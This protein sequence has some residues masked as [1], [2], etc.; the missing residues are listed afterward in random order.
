ML[1]VVSIKKASID[2]GYYLKQ[3][4]DYY[5][6]GGNDK[7]L[8]Q[9]VGKG[10]RVL[11]L[12]GDVTLKDH[13]NVFNGILPGNI[14]VGKRNPDGSLAG[15]PGYDLTF[16]MNKD[17]SLII[18]CTKDK[19]LKD[20]FLNAHIS[21]VKTVMNEVENL[22]SARKTVNGVTGYEFTKN[23]V[24][25]LCTHF[26]SRAGDPEVHTHALI[27]NATQRDDGQWR[28]LSTDM[29]REHG[30]F[31][32]VRDNA[33]F[34]GH[35]Y[36]NEMARATKEK[37]FGVVPIKKHGMFAI[38]SFPDDVKQHFSKRRVQIEGIVDSL[39][40]A[41]KTDRML[42][43][44]VAQ[45][46]RPTKVNIKHHDLMAKSKADMKDYLDAHHNHKDF[47]TLIKACMDKEEVQ[48]ERATDTSHEA[49][50]D[51]VKSLSRFNVSMDANAIIKKAMSYDLGSSSIQSLWVSLEDMIKGDV[52]HRTSDGHLT[53][54][55][56]IDKENQLMRL[57]NRM[58]PRGQAG[59]AVK[60]GG[61]GLDALHKE[62]LCVLEEPS[63][64]NDKL[65]MLDTLI[66]DL[67]SAGKTVTLLTQTKSL[68][69]KHN[70]HSSVHPQSL[71]QRLIRLKKEDRAKGLYGFLHQEESS[72]RQGSHQHQPVWVIDDA[73]R[74]NLDAAERLLKLA[75]KKKAGLIFLSDEKGRQSTNIVSLL[76]KSKVTYISADDHKKAK[77]IDHLSCHVHEI[78]TDF[79][80]KPH[81]KQSDRQRQLADNIVRQYG[82]TL[83]S[84]QI[85]AMTA[86]SAKKQSAWVRQALKRA[87]LIGKEDQQI[88]TEKTVYLSAEEKKHAKFFKKGWVVKTYVGKGQFTEKS[89]ERLDEKNN[90]LVVKGTFGREKFILPRQLL[91]DPDA[92]LVERASLLISDQER[93]RVNK[94]GRL[95]KQLGLSVNTCYQVS[96]QGKKIR[97]QPDDSTLKTINTTLSR[98]RGADL[99]HDYVRSLNQIQNLQRSDKMAIL[100]APSY[101]LNKGVIHTLGR[102]F[103]RLDCYTDNSEKA[104]K[105]MGIQID[106]VLASDLPLAPEKPEL[107]TLQKAVNY[108]IA[109]IAS[110]E[111]AFTY[112]SVVEKSLS[113][114][115]T[116]VNFKSIR[117]ELRDRVKAGELMARQSPTG[118]IVIATQETI[119]LEQ[120]IIQ[121]I[122]S[123]K[124]SVTPFLGQADVQQK[125]DATS[126][127]EGQ[128]AACALLATTSDRFVM[129]QGYAGTGKSTML[130]TLQAAIETSGVIDRER[131]IAVAPTH[132]AVQELLL[133]GIQAQTLKSFLVDEVVSENH[134]HLKDKLILLD[135]S[136]MVS[137]RDWQMLE[138]VVEKAESCHCAYIGDKAQLLGVEDG[139]PS[140]LA[141]FSR[142]A[143]IATAT[144]DEV[145]R[146]KTPELKNVVRELVAGT[147]ESMGRAFSELDKQ[148]SIID[149]AS[150]K[151][152]EVAHPIQR[153]AEYY[154]NLSKSD[155]AQTVIAAATNKSRAA[156]NH[157]IRIIRQAKGELQGDSVN[158]TILID[159]GLT[160]AELTHAP[161]YKKDNVVKFNDVYFDVVKADRQQNM[162]LLKDGEGQEQVLNLNEIAPYAKLEL[163]YRETIEIQAGDELKWTKSDKARKLT[164]HDGLLVSAVNNQDSTITAKTKD[165]ESLAIDLSL[166][167]NQHMDYRY[168]STVH[169]LQGATAKLALV[170]LDFSNRLSN[171]MR[172]LYVAATRATHEVKVFTN[173]L[174]V[175][176][177]QIAKNKGDKASAL[178]AMGLLPIKQPVA[179]GSAAPSHVSA[180]P[181]PAVQAI[182]P[183]RKGRSSAAPPHVSSKPKPAAQ[184]I[185]PHQRKERIDA[186]LVEDGLRHQVQTICE[187]FFGKPKQ[188]LSNANNWRYGKKGS[189]SVSVGGSYQ[190]SFHN[191][192]TG[193]KGGMIQLLMSELG[194]DFKAA[195]EEGHRMVGGD[196]TIKPKAKMKAPVVMDD[197]ANARKLSYL[198]S[199]VERSQSIQ[200]TVAEKY[201]AGRAIQH[202]S[203][204][205][206]RYIKDINT[207]G[208]NQDIKRYADGLLAIAKDALGQMTAIQVT[209]LDPKTGTKVTGL[210]IKKRTIGSLK[211]SSV[212]LTPEVTSPNL[213][214]VAEGIETALSIKDAIASAEKSQVQ[215]LATLGKSNLAKVAN[216]RSADK[217]VLV[218]DNDKQDWQ[219][220]KS[221]K[222]AIAQME[223]QGKDVR[224]IQPKLINDQKTDY[225]DLAK[226]G[227]FDEIRRDIRQGIDQL[228][229]KT[230]PDVSKTNDQTNLNVDKNINKAMRIDRD[231]FG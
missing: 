123:G 206:L 162:V 131:I 157:N 37:G 177:E 220:D 199:L 124:N 136:S 69:E 126:L 95:T 49:V 3:D 218:L 79:N 29:Q 101:A 45:H 144:M 205:D 117:S 94:A 38:E 145:L 204:T 193:E 175:V 8:Y 180:K 164:A 99:S 35:I 197:S 188:S 5:I 119:A 122:K 70:D 154:C 77:M 9:W 192:E 183:Q 32:K 142:E 105:K 36:Q 4:G 219:K 113:Y 20:Y 155:R 149:E 200:G 58:Q 135:E 230:K 87:G 166:P 12:V 109:V 114:G 160:N 74:L 190:G 18:C 103:E 27:A 159:S 185:T 86:P 229:D 186:K 169:G 34:L 51:A 198:K 211:T 222:G 194:L 225:N 143:D 226:A 67:E 133:K 55:A 223:A 2:D 168:A 120:S 47:D 10:A 170:L 196:L 125:L 104:Q 138:T 28:A 46:S 227:K 148:G 96:L 25:S 107:S 111:A 201:L 82:S 73:G 80:A 213:T 216:E 98:L 42:Y 127:T 100:E 128:K 71:W 176:R 189:L 26:S 88:V 217:I 11:G 207:G 30:F 151:A 106:K 137:N 57:V 187:N 208:G 97:L 209:Y 50:L 110:R 184:A 40:Y 56:L 108:G 65:T 167:N 31:E 83:D 85:L 54:Q 214:L 140:E 91:K 84:I 24:A 231:L 68:A 14:V 61:V 132:K 13:T 172:L 52:L 60:K 228:D 203:T 76:K 158:S 161:N 41:D 6:E 115:G 93:I 163:F 195:L 78:K 17:I 202:R 129:V 81:E 43:N 174:S 1:S 156:L 39:K 59:R 153:L 44:E 147:P 22:V 173:K 33:T 171:T 90:R 21:A 179:H 215:V 66:N 178:E 116:D 224:C 16:S 191:F 72:A 165:G 62:R 134:Q 152:H 141:Y 7:Q 118:D 121:K 23:M 150:S 75:D 92:K 221:I 212:N 19:A 130:Q 102:H 48:L 15:R 89:I 181:K 139:K 182:T 210:P 146:Q 64:L 63:K 53:S 112:Q